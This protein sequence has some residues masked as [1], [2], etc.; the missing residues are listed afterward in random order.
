M[1]HTGP[2][3]DSDA[4]KVAI[5]LSHS[6]SV[7]SDYGWLLPNPERTHFD[8]CRVLFPVHQAAD[9]A[10]CNEVQMEIQVRK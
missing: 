2:I 7:H 4:M 3:E 8:D 1:P 6:F 10:L 5:I 9:G